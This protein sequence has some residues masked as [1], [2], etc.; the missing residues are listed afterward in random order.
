MFTLAL[1]WP[2]HSNSPL[3]R[4]VS[5]SHR[6]AHRGATLAQAAKFI[7]CVR[8][9]CCTRAPSDHFLG[10]LFN[11]CAIQQWSSLVTIHAFP[12]QISP[13]PPTYLYRTP[14]APLWATYKPLDP[15]KLSL[16]QVVAV[17][18]LE[19]RSSSVAGVGQPGCSQT[20][21]VYR[22]R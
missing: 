17:G 7:V 6:G 10:P 11:S 21:K 15:M 16:S 3:M 5:R 8:P 19:D 14:P 22:Y 4:D 13:P 9:V 2:A 18:R 12:F 20:Y 1:Q